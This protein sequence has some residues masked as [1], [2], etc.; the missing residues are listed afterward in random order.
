[1][2]TM[3]ARSVGKASYKRSCKNYSGSKIHTSIN[4]GARA[5]NRRRKVVGR[6]SHLIY[7]ARQPGYDTK[8]MLS[9]TL[10]AGTTPEHR[11]A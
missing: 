10:E 2:S 9:P 8:H 3:K 5:N 1:M 11:C 6:I 4:T 7:T